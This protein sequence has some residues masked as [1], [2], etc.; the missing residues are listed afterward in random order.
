MFPF[1]KTGGL[2]DVVGALATTLGRRGHEVEVFLPGYRAILESPTGRGAEVT[3]RFK[4]SLGGRDLAGEVRTLTAGRGV[5]LHLV[6]RDEYFD[7]THL[8]WNGVRDYDDN[9]AR[10]LFFQKAVIELLLRAGRHVDVLHAHDWQTGL[11]P[12]LWRQAE[13]R[14]GVRLVERTVFT[15]HNLAYQGV[16]PRETFGLTGLHH[17]LNTMEG[18]EYYGG[19]SFL[20]AG[21]L[22]ADKVTTVSPT[23]ARE[24]R[25]AEAG[26]GMDGVVRFRGAALSGIRNGIDP[27]V[28]N[29]A[30]DAL[31]PARY[32][33]ANPAGKAVC[34]AALLRSCGW[35]EGY[36]GPVFG[37]VSRMT[38]AKGHDLVLGAAD[39]FVRHDCRL[40]VLGAGE[41]GFEQAFRELAAAHPGRV[42]VRI[43]GD[44]T[45]S[46]L[47]EAGADFFL[48]PSRAEP[49]GLNQMY[50]QVYGTIPLAGRT[51]GLIDTVV[52]LGEKP[53][54]GTGFLFRP[55]PAEFAAALGRALALFAD[56]P[57]LAAAQRRG[58]EKDF[59]WESVIP[60]Y[61]S[62]YG[63]KGAAPD[64]G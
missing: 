40:V 28:W 57:A 41:A 1:V 16:F 12:L 58:M 37:M 43:K 8:Y 38:R 55:E 11:L 39:F 52:D 42:S 25:T 15:I 24:I 29:P 31:L 10:F 9:D 59:S 2:A 4:V 50:S 62:L 27:A 21:I 53:K 64:H 18:I 63:L 45:M 26:L 23:Y 34:R 48:M 49:C 51:G 56:K 14:A 54:R 19:I 17:S 7:R 5:T 36:A 61:E 60:A 46:H 22:Y 35:D 44:E 20:K 30:T 47:I 6:V 33:P 13:Q 3:A 32:E